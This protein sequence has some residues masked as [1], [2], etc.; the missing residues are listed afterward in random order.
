MSGYRPEKR[1]DPRF[2]I[3]IP[4]T[5]SF[6]K[7]DTPPVSCTL[8]TL[9]LSAGGVNLRTAFDIPLGTRVEV[10]LKLPFRLTL[11]DADDIRVSTRGAVIRRTSQGVAVCFEDNFHVSYFPT[12]D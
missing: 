9:D 1:L 5:L 7:I 12:L 8:P 2:D 6:D 3:K 11:L 4:A 10:N